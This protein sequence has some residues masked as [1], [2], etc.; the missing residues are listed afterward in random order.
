MAR[1][2]NEELDAIVRNEQEWRRVMY[3]DLQDFGDKLHEV[4]KRASSNALK[5]TFFVGGLNL[6]FTPIVV[7]V[8]NFFKETM[9]P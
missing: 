8:L 6:I 2:T 3:N 7:T 4:D 1:K 5:L 9:R